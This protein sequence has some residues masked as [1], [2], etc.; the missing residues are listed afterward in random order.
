MAK[1]HQEAQELVARRKQWGASPF[2]PYIVLADVTIATIVVFIL[3]LLHSDEKKN[4]YADLNQKYVDLNQKYTTLTA[5]ERARNDLADEVKVKTQEFDKILDAYS[6][7]KG[8]LS[9][10]HARGPSSY[11]IR[12]YGNIFEPQIQGKHVPAGQ[13]NTD[14]PKE[15]P[16]QR[17]KEIVGRLSLICKDHRKSKPALIE[18][19]IQGHAKGPKRDDKYDLELSLSRARA[20]RDLFP[21]DQ[22]HYISVSGFGADRPAYETTAL[23]L[24]KLIDP[25]TQSDLLKH[26]KTFD[27]PE[28]SSEPQPFGRDEFALLTPYFEKPK[29]AIENRIDVVLE[30]SGLSKENYFVYPRL[31]KGR[32]LP[33][34]YNDVSTPKTQKKFLERNQDGVS[35]T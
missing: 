20:L 4:E 16:N 25:A 9:I 33:D 23:T 13:K 1:N 18:I 24:T 34:Y 32:T 28:G 22:H 31:E 12:L 10:S 14:G 7:D 19:R 29:R 27:Q 30:Y 15:Q 3:L 17:V 5:A 2:N 8:N 21:A 11:L 26:L 35:G 6:W